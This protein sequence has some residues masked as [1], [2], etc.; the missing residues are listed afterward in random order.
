MKKREKKTNKYKASPY[1]FQTSCKTDI[2]LGLDVWIK[3]SNYICMSIFDSIKTLKNKCFF[4]WFKNVISTKQAKFE[5]YGYQKYS[6]C[7]L[8][9]L[10][11]I[12]WKSLITYLGLKHW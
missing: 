11:R 6:M 1:F 10:F 9:Q 12:V 4:L 2:P 3:F 5:L 8:V 7:A